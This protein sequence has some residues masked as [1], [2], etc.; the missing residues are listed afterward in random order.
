MIFATIAA[1]EF[2]DELSLSA[3][4]KK[5]RAEARRLEY[6]MRGC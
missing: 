3:A 2:A 6:R 4:E 1:F 5:R